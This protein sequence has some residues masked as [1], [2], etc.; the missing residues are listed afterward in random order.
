MKLNDG[1]GCM[2]NSKPVNWM[3]GAVI[4]AM[5]AWLCFFLLPT[6]PGIEP[7]D[8]ALQEAL[9]VRLFGNQTLPA[10]QVDLRK[11]C[12]AAGVRVEFPPG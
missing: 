1:L 12:H 7:H 9:M 3:A 6:P 11:R 8:P 10:L 5:T 4:V 2:K